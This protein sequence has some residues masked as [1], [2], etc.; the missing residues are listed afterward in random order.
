MIAEPSR[1]QGLR[2]CV[3]SSHLALSLQGEALTSHEEKTLPSFSI[4]LNSL[5]CELF[6]EECLQ[7]HPDSASEEHGSGCHW[8][9][10]QTEASS[11]TM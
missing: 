2:G 1:C 9:F 5:R 7:T 11:K 4:L 6:K 10:N 3:C 8:L